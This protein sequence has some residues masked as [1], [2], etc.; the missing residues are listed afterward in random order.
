[1]QVDCSYAGCTRGSWW[2]SWA[3]RARET[4]TAIS[5]MEHLPKGAGVSVVV[6]S[7]GVN[8]REGL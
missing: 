2:A 1:M 6:G 4:I 7:S 3:R 8:C 5:P